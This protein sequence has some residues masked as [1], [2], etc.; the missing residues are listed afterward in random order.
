MH[1]K[2]LVINTGSTTTKIAIFEG[3]K[4][5]LFEKIAHK[6][7]ILPQG[8]FFSTQVD[9]RKQL[10]QKTL[11]QHNIS[12]AQIDL[13]MC[14]GGLIK[15][16]ASGVYVVNDKMLSDLKNA[17]KQHASNLAAVIGARLSE[18]NIPV[19]IADPVVVDELQDVARFAGHKDFERIS[20][21]HALNHKAVARRYA[22]SIGIRYESLNLIV[23]HLGGGIS[24]GAHKKG[25]VVDVNQ[26][27][28]GEGPFSPERSGTLPA[29]DLV[30]MAYSGDYTKEEMLQ[31]IVGKGGLV[32]YLNSNNIQ[33]ITAGLDDEKR[34][35]LSAMS[36]QISKAIGEMAVVLQ[37]D[38][39]A[40]IL[41]GGVAHNKMIAS[42]IQKQVSFLAPV[43]V[44]PGEDEMKALAMNGLLVW[45]KDLEPKKY[46]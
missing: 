4:Q 28:D 29:G 10:I 32:S 35:V 37:G 14:R 16:V 42:D 6:T 9:F 38:V 20:I 31:K 43:K 8:D 19:Y 15:P 34:M 23:A 30:R 40:I 3:G 21:F 36:Y 11:S 27:L 33:D 18:G 45:Y 39:D 25:R 12:M 5:L 26:A 22:S 17:Q 2:T 7:S 13:I 1:P 24:V 44:F 41:T 46:S